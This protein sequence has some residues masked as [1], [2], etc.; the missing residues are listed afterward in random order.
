ME[1]QPDR[2]LLDIEL[3]RGEMMELATTSTYTNKRVVELS[4]KLD[5]L[6]NKYYIM[7]EKKWQ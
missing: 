6:L 1:I 3:C 2:L 4:T 7:T 5:E